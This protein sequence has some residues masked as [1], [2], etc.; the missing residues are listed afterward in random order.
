MDW[1][2]RMPVIG[3]AAKIPE[4][5]RQAAHEEVASLEHSTPT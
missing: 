4:A 2:S 1:A 5:L 3:R